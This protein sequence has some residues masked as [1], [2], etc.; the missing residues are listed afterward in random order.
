MKFH[1]WNF[2]D[3]NK[4]VHADEISLIDENKDLHADEISLL[5]IRKV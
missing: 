2:I 1:W 5:R 3:E 4:G